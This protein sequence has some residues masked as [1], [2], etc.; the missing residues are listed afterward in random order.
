MTEQIPHISLGVGE[1]V[2][3]SSASNVGV[4]KYHQHECLVL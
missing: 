2:D 4:L 1:G 3:K